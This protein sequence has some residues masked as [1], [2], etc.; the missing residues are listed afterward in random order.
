MEREPFLR[1]VNQPRLNNA[2][3]AAPG[4]MPWMFN[5]HEP[6]MRLMETIYK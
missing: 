1:A 4:H 3:G 2:N 6:G 5:Q